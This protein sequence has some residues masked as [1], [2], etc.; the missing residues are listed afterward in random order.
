MSLLAL[1]GGLSTTGSLANDEIAQFT[2]DSLQ[3]VNVQVNYTA[4]N[5][6]FTYA[7]GT[8]VNE[9]TTVVMGTIADDGIYDWY[10]IRYFSTC[11]GFFI[12]TK[13]LN[14]THRGVGYS[15]RLSDLVQEDILVTPAQ[16]EFKNNNPDLVT[17][18]IVNVTYPWDDAILNIGFSTMPSFVLLVI[19]ILFTVS[20][21]VTVPYFLKTR[22]NW[23]PLSI[24]PALSFIF[25][26]SGTAQ[27]CTTRDNTQRSWFQGYLSRTSNI[28]TILLALS[29][30]C[31]FVVLI[32][33]AFLAWKKSSD[34]DYAHAIKSYRDTG[35]RRSNMEAANIS[36][37]PVKQELTYTGVPVAYAPSNATD[38]EP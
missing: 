17:N 4:V 37:R 33:P 7:N 25:L 30:S 21:L 23:I 36:Y 16:I 35:G 34:E 2:T 8:T 38:G 26:L 9:N 3:I 20:S 18:N 12:S 5:P 1:L 13:P 28:F 6:P 11:K 27:I 19:G 15:F 32:S 31:I 24:G 22:P 14:C 10:S 29:I